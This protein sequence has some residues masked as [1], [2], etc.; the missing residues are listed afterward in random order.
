MHTRWYQHS[1]HGSKCAI[2]EKYSDPRVATSAIAQAIQSSVP[3]NVSRTST[4]ARRAGADASAASPS[5]AS[6]TSR[7]CSRTARA[8]R[9]VAM[10]SVMRLP[11]WCPNA[12]TA[13]GRAGSDL[14]GLG[15][16]RADRLLAEPR[17]GEHGERGGHAVRGVLLLG[18]VRAG[19]QV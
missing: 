16:V 11:P 1:R 2:S 19:A 10:T 6:R 3:S 4:R 7:T 17:L 18:A 8:A 13:G 5:S 14:R 9:A 15:D 12:R